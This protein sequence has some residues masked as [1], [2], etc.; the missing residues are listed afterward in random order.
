[1]Q[2]LKLEAANMMKKIELLEAAKRLRFLNSFH[3][4][5]LF[6]FTHSLT[7]EEHGALYFIPSGNSWEKVWG[8]VPLRNC[9]G[10]NNSWRGV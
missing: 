10:L 8:L 5:K 3:L 1:L 9:Y 7:M 4:D 6:I 2:H